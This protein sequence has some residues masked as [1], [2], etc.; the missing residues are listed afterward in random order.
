MTRAQYL[1][2]GASLAAFAF[3]APAAAQTVPEPQAGPPAGTVTTG[4]GDSAPQGKSGDATSGTSQSATPGRPSTTD[5]GG[6]IIVTAQRRSEALQQVPISVSAFTGQALERQQIS[7]ASD[8]QLSLPNVTF[9]KTN[10]TSSSFTI[11]GIGDLCTGFSCDAATGI[12][13]NDMPLV[14]TRLFETEYFD[15]ERVEV[16]RGPQGTLF[17]RNATSGV[18]NFITAR[19]N[20]SRAAASASVEVGNYQS[21]KLNAMVNLPLTDTLGVRVAGYLLGR[22]GYT[23]NLFDNSRIDGR[24]LWALRGS[25]R[26]K[27]SA[28]TTLDVIGYAFNEDDDRS[29][30]QKQLCHRDPTGVL[31]CLPDRLANEVVNGNSTL[32]ATLSSRQFINAAAGFNPLIA[33]FGLGLTNLNS[34]VDP[35]FGGITNPSDLRTVNADF[36]PT[37]RAK[38]YFVMGR[39]EQNLGDQFSATL[40][41]GW[42]KNSVDSRT[43]YNL[44]AGNSLAGNSGLVN[45]YGL[46]LAPGAAFP[47]GVN[48]FTN[49]VRALIPNGPLGNICTSETN[50]NYTGIYGGFTNRCTPGSTDYDR[51]QSYYRQYSLEGHIDSNFKGPFN[52]LLGGIYLDGRFTNSNYYVASA[53]LDYA[54]GVLGAIQALGQRAAGATFPNSFLAPPFFNSEVSDFRLKSYGLFGEAYF[55]ASDKLKFTL[56]ARYSHDDKLQVARAPILSFL[57]P[58]GLTDANQSPFL[59][60]YDADASTA[61]NQ[62]NAVG[63]VKFGR[64]TGRLVADYQMTPN[65]L[66]YASY[67]RG[68]KSGG[69]NPPIDPSFNVS[70]TFKPESID[71][72]ELGSKN[73]FAG[74]AVRL[75]LSAF[76]YNY[77][78]LQL[79]RIVARTSVN[80][81]TDAGI[82]GAEAEAV[83]KPTPDLLLN[84]TGSYLHTKIKGLSLVDPR[85]PSGGRS[86][87]VIIKD[88][89]GGANCVVSPAV[90]GV[91]AAAVNGFVGAVNGALGL[92]PPTPIPSTNTTGAF[93]LCSALQG[94]AA[95]P[96]AALRTAFGVPAGPLPF[97]VNEGIAQNL[98]GN[99]LPQ[100]PHWK[101][102]GGAQYTLRLGNGMT[103]VPRADVNYTG[104]FYARSFN[105][106]IDK[107]KGFTV[108]N[109][110]VQLNGAADKWFVRAF[111]QNLTNNDAI[112]GQFVADA[113]SGLFTNVFTLEP[114]RF[115]A[116]IGVKF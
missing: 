90:A 48:P 2:A 13:V 7:N 50:L 62:A 114:R 18:V 4:A 77:K 28:G 8:L 116:A 25:I 15:L 47:G 96:S 32:S 31:G 103:L 104:S 92:N 22:D 76:Y 85:D 102:G 64:L 100:S 84:L 19:P 49:A 67:S 99:Q 71:A 41:G 1:L 108:V 34:G 109:A 53:G 101:V 57:V 69:L 6:D 58:F 88:L 95:N 61:G 42:A 45:L 87:A 33:S 111:V 30:I 113:S 54:S 72:F 73:T 93:S 55:Q 110:Q 16:L 23:K 40:T 105:Q 35:F 17:G 65:N 80:D 66:L 52:F 91:P 36:N 38:E 112:T 106:P 12:H 39:L 97:L 81:N 21:V 78:G 60:L 26:W 70:P 43:D 10:F 44:L 3:V 89:Q 29:R 56:G 86:D 63:R 9:T 24:D 115:G 46:S 79:S 74:G 75:N 51:S 27:P 82:Y 83:F 5:T 11:R 14:S 94:A 59:G 37:Y 68:Y 98:S 20:L 107:V